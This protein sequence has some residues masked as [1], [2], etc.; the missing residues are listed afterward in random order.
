MEY[1]EGDFQRAFLGFHN[2]DQLHYAVTGLGVA[3]AYNFVTHWR[4][5][6]DSYKQ[7]YEL[8]NQFRS[9]RKERRQE[10]KMARRYRKSGYKRRRT[11]KY[12][13]GKR[14]RGKRGYGGLARRVSKISRMLRTK[15]VRNTEIK[16]QEVQSTVAVGPMTT[17]L[18]PV[19]SFTNVIGTGSGYAARTG[20][21]VF[22]RKIKLWIMLGAKTGATNPEQYVRVFVV[23]DKQPAAAAGLPL[24]TDVAS[25]AATAVT[26]QTTGNLSLMTFQWINNRFDGRFNIL[27]SGMF[28]VVNESGSG[29]KT[30][31]I[32]KIIKVFKPAEF[33]QSNT[34]TDLGPGQLYLYAYSSD[35][36]TTSTN[37]VDMNYAYRL[38]FTDV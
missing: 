17:A 28:K 11:G 3:T 9:S 24:F 15:G 38:S 26:N 10:E 23:R 16:Y 30:R 1:G 5:N 27:W 20:G 21:K 29:E 19:L 32:K 37:Q 14:R 22:V 33:G 31:L 25:P 7:A 4:N 8:Y 36:T 34:G 18:A 12:K 13:Y 35:P 2:S 6:Y